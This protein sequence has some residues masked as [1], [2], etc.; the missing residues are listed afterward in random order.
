MEILRDYDDILD[1]YKCAFRVVRTEHYKD[2]FGWAI[3]HYQG[4]D[5]PALQCIWPDRNHKFPW[6]SEAGSEFRR[7]TIRL[8]EDDLAR[9]RVLAAEK[10]LRYQTYLKMLLHEALNSEEHKAGRP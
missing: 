2:L 10:G 3:S 7:I 5:F 6:A 8:A 4:T 1:G 9:A